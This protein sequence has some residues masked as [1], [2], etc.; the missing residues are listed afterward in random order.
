MKTQAQHEA[1]H[2]YLENTRPTLLP[3]LS[4][5]VSWGGGT[6]VGARS[7]VLGSVQNCTSS[8]M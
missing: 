3:T 5:S 7:L 4:L 2:S 1:G 6:E 8:G